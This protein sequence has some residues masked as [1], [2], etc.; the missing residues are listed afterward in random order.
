MKVLKKR[1]PRGTK[2]NGQ[3][4]YDMCPDCYMPGCDPFGGSKLYRDK[5]EKRLKEGKCPACG[6]VDCK[7]KSTILSP[8]RWE[9][10]ENRRK[11]YAKQRQEEEE[12]YD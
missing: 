8:K 6:Q 10:R 12:N 7:C 4:S 9:E 1:K 5:I 11:E 2:L 3:K